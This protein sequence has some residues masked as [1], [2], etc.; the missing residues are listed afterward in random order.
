MG[1]LLVAVN[2]GIKPTWSAFDEHFEHTFTKGMPKEAVYKELERLC[3][4]KYKGVTARSGMPFCRRVVL[5]V[6][7]VGLSQREFIFCFDKE[8]RLVIVEPYYDEGE[9]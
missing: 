1:L 7:L 2:V 8:H 6:G 5:V 4:V 9:S 3:P